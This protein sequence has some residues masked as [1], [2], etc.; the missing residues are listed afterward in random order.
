MYEGCNLTKEESKLLILSFTLRHSLSDLGLSHLLQ[1]IDCHL[2]HVQYKSKYLFCKDFET[3][4]PVRKIYYCQ[5]CET[6]IL[7]FEDNAAIARCKDC[8]NEYNK[9]NLKRTGH[10]FMYLPLTEQLTNMLNNID[11]SQH[12]KQQYDKESDVISGKVYRKLI[13]T[14]V[15]SKTDITLQWNTDGVQTHKS[16][17]VSMWPIQVSINE[18]PYRLRRQ[19]MI[20]CG[21]WYGSKKPVMELF[22]KPFV[23]ELI[24]LHNDGIICKLPL[25]RD[26]VTVKIHVLL[27]SVDSVARPLL[28]NM[29][30]FNGHFGCSFCLNEGQRVSIGAGYTRVYCGGINILRNMRQ[31]EADCEEAVNKRISVRGIKGPSILMTIPIFNIISSFVPDYMH[32]VLLGVVRT[33]VDA[34]FD[35]S[36]SDKPWY[37]GKFLLEFDRRLTKIKPP[38]EISRTPRSINDRKLW[39][40]S[41]WKNYLLYYSIPC[42]TNLMPSKYIKHWF[43]LTFSIS[44]F[45]KDKITTH[46]FDVA[47]AAVQ[48]FVTQVE[49]LYGKEF[50][51]YNVHMLLH[52]PKSVQNFGALWSHSAFP[53]EHYNGILGKLFK[54]S[55]CVPEQICKSY[56]RLKV[57]DKLSKTVWSLEDYKNTLGNSLFV[58][59]FGKCKI[60]CSVEH[61][62]SLRL[63]GRYRHMSLSLIQ[64]TSIETLLRESV[65][66]DVHSYQR[67]IF[68]SV[69]YHSIDY[70]RLV[71]RC[72]DTVELNCGTYM[73]IT[74]IFIV[75]TINLRKKCVV[76]GN[77]LL[78]LN[79]EI[80]K[81]AELRISSKNYAHIMEQSDRIICIEPQSINKK[82]VR[83]PY[84]TLE[85]KVCIIPLVN[86][87]ETD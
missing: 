49:S 51:K 71:K 74:H 48:K 25:H 37:M 39:K 82:C 13:D 66:N 9:D 11:I 26:P 4:V 47:K 10:Y 70:N 76:M 31:H 84:G 16:S 54:N 81:D 15:I 59:M 1:L 17:K 40:A 55:Q 8:G 28:Q 24:R 44:I 14:H 75:S 38:S 79:I 63:F 52:I 18:L 6:N 23:Q 78:P 27:A 34:C 20:L 21:L 46:E 2:P 73:V 45:L 19:N 68:Q 32:C 58:K 35:S 50:V 56:Q 69:L 83:I 62:N 77:Q 33:I 65:L 57:I 80:V 29:K 3:P 60:Q 86:T 36:Y 87:V 61:D 43:L 12:L 22:L 5:D 42:M 7:E 53:Y 67:F 30:Q 64:Q 72:N 41:E 85:D